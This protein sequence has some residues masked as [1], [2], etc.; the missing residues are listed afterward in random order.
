ML[1]PSYLKKG[2]TIGIVCPSGYMPFEQ[3]KKCIEILTR[4]GFQVKLGKTAG[5]QF[6][7]FSGTDADR[8]SDLQQMLDDKNTKAILCGRGGYGLSRIID[9]IDFSAFRTFPKWIIGYSDITLLHT[10]LNSELKIASLHAPMAAAFNDGENEFVLSLL[11]T[12]TGKETVYTCG[13]HLLNRIGNAEG[14]LI[15][16]NLSLLVHSIGSASEVQTENKILFIEDIGEYIYATDRMLLQLKRAG[17]L[18]D[19]KALIAGSF[20][21]MKD[22]AIPFGQTIYEAIYDKIKEYN[23]PVCF[24]F[25][26]GH[27]EKN[28]ALKCGMNYQLDVSKNKVSLSSR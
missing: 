13:T 10:H 4:W 22:T 25:P 7:Y 5:S 24:D 26:V 8:L 16:G 28:Y 17:K 20:T 11:K 2:D 27:T 19:L 18:S 14:E 6:H 21:D 12:L 3:I 1:I 15:G 9:G 23:Y